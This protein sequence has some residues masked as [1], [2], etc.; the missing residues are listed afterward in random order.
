[1]FHQAG[2]QRLLSNGNSAG[3]LGRPGSLPQNQIRDTEGAG[4]Q[5]AAGRGRG[6]QQRMAPQRQHPAAQF[7]GVE[8]WQGEVNRRLRRG[9][10]LMRLS[11]YGEAEKDLRKALEKATEAVGDDVGTGC[12]RRRRRHRW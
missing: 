2:Q 7:T 4:G 8:T 10:A 3:E 9:T 11:R 5:R 1:M 6:V 12:G